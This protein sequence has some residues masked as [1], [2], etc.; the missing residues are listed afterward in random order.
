MNRYAAG[1]SA[2]VVVVCLTVALSFVY[3][4]ALS[5]PHA[6]T[7][8]EDRVTV[9]ERDAYSVTG[10]IVY[11][12]QTVA[13]LDGTVAADGAWYQRRRED[14]IV[15]ETYRP[16]GSDTV[17]E[18]RSIDDRDVA[19]GH[20][21]WIADDEAR[22]LRS[23]NRTA[24]G[25]TLVVAEN[26]TDPTEQVSGVASV[27]VRNLFVV[28]YERTDS[29]NGTLYRPQPGWYSGTEPYRVV[30]ATGQVRADA[31]TNAVMSANITLAVQE[32]VRTYAEYAFARLTGAS[33]ETQRVTVEFDTDDHTL[34]RPAW[35][36]EAMAE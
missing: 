8:P 17:Y 5:D 26:A 34:H 18:R 33:P 6:A 15:T 11:E 36:E 29:S 13:A 4:F 35:V 16:S 21:D 20:R 23:W 24:D 30:T 28:A 3:P 19:E 31:E 1:A 2:G 27:F 9:G 32:S 7:P 25:V 14:G 22:E 10:R 12:G